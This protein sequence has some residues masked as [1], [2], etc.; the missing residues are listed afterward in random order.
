M[1]DDFN[2]AL[3]L[4]D[5]FALF[6]NIS[7]RIAEG[8]AGVADDVAQIRKTYSL[9]GL[10]KK[11]AKAYF[12]EVEKKNPA[13]IPAEVEELAGRRWQAKQSRNW[14]E[15]DALRAQIDAMGY[16]VK[17]GKDGYKVEKK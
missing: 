5:L 13:E 10:F 16:T 2:T 17:D 12:A 4:S 1:S 8:D 9:L 3:A 14:A 6:K 7:S 11:D 15:A